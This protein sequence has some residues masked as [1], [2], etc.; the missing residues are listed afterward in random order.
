MPA[1]V[2]TDEIVKIVAAALRDDI[3]LTLPGACMRA[4]AQ[5][6]YNAIKQAMVR[7]RQDKA[8]DEEVERIAPIIEAI[9]Y[10]CS[11]LVNSGLEA[12][13]AN[14]RTGFYEFLLS[15]KNRTEYGAE[16]KM[17][18]VGKDGADLIQRIDNELRGM[19]V[20]DLLNMAIGAEK[21]AK[22]GE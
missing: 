12:A 10:Q 20:K 17:E 4:E 6:A 11:Q 18:L 13:A 19:P 8:T 22:E 1:Q 16:Q 3:T 15:R 5:R 14:G 7:V 2:I 9:E 21:A